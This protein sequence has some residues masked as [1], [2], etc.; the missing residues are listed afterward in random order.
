MYCAFHEWNE[1]N[2]LVKIV[3]YREWL[4]NCFVNNTN[5]INIFII[6]LGIFILKI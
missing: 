4:K 3:K 5:N 2:S 1:Y 6:L